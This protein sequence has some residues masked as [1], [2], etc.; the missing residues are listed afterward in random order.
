MKIANATDKEDDWVE[1]LENGSYTSRTMIMKVRGKKVAVRVMVP[2]AADYLLEEA[3]G[4]LRMAKV[5]E[6]T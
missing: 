4:L 5:E 3:C 1:R 2:L 6:T